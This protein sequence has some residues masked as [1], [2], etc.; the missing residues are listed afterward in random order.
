MFQNTTA[1][2]R[3]ELLAVMQEA[4]NVDDKFIADLIYPAYPVKTR[5]GFYMRIKKGTGAL[6][7]TEGSDALKRAPGTPYKQVSRT[8]EQDGWKAVDRGLKEPLDDVNSQDTARFFDVESSTAVWLQ[9]N[10]RIATEQRVAASVFGNTWGSNNASVTMIAA[11]RGTM[12][13]P[14][15]IRTAKR[16]VDKRGEMSN[17]CVMSR[18]LWDLIAI[19]DLLKLFF[20]GQLNGASMITP[21]MFAEK[22]EL[23]QV[24]IGNASYATS[25]KNKTVTDA[26]LAW[27]WPVDKIWIGQVQGGPPEAGG[28]GRRFVLEDT[29]SGGQL[30][31]VETYRDEDLRSDIIRVREDTDEKVVNENSGTIIQAIL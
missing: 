5:T 10:I 8:F 2:F 15:D 26:D 13:V 7:H 3:P 14:L 9:R 18:E 27:C 31:V 4:T 1:E 24:L 19:S 11:N 22:F 28:A 16:L 29:T 6:L 20:F 23:Q 30:R 25:G 21:Q 12:D 17:T